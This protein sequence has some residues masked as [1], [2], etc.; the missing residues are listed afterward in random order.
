[1]IQGIKLNASHIIMKRFYLVTLLFV[2]TS[3][4]IFAQSNGYRQEKNVNMPSHQGR[5]GNSETE[6]YY[7]FRI[8]AGFTSIHSDLD[9]LDADAT[10][11][12]LNIGAVLG[13]AL[14]D[15]SPIYLET[16][17]YYTE[18]GGKMGSGDTRKDFNLDYL[19]LPL[20]AKYVIETD[21]DFSIQPLAGGYVALGIAGEIK[22]YSIRKSH[23]SYSNSAFQRFDAGLRI[24]CGL[25]YELF[26]AEMTY[27]IGLTNIS[28]DSFDKAHTSAF[29]LTAG[30]NF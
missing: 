26:Y 6:M 24:G 5:I 11:T 30:V 29:M 23:T 12:G 10:K 25:A 21:Y 13:F 27:D 2:I 8:G 19:L 1:M 4:S 28:S 14:S 16:G 22:D 18:K 9:A 17:L 15:Y 7:G 20:T 3:L